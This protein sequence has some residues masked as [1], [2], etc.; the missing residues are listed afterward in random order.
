MLSW[1][2]AT[3]VWL[4]LRKLYVDGTLKPCISRRPLND[5]PDA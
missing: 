2:R 4:T 3:S 1:L 5:L